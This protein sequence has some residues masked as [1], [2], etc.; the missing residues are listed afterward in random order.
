M[1][2]W[3]K[4]IILEWAKGQE[5]KEQQR[6][7]ELRAEREEAQLYLANL[8]TEGMCPHVAKHPALRWT[9][10]DDCPLGSL[11]TGLSW[12]ASKRL[13]TLSRSYSK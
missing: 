6:R 10:C 13:C 7:K 4:E 5:K 12:G 1:K 11:N 3:L 9:Y 2:T 8:V